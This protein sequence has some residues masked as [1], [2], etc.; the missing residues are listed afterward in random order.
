[1]TARSENEHS[2]AAQK[3]GA[4]PDHETACPGSTARAHGESGPEE[5]PSQERDC[6]SGPRPLMWTSSPFIPQSLRRG[7]EASGHVAVTQAAASTSADDADH[8]G[9]DAAAPPA[10]QDDSDQCQTEDR[11]RADGRTAVGGDAPCAMSPSP[12][13]PQ[14]P[15]S[16]A[17]RDLLVW[18]DCEFT[19]LDPECD[20]IIE[21]AV[22]ITD[23][24]LSPVVTFATPIR[25][26]EEVLQRMSLWA[27]QVHGGLYQRRSPGA[28]SASSSSAEPGTTAP[29][30][31]PPLRCVPCPRTRFRPCPPRPA[32][33]DGRPEPSLVDECRSDARSMPLADA[34]AHIVRILDAHR[35]GRRL[36]L[37]GSSVYIDKMFLRRWMPRVDERLHYRVIDVS[38]L[39]EVVR[40]FRPHLVRAQPANRVTHRALGDIFSSISLLRFYV[41]LLPPLLPAHAPVFDALDFVGPQHF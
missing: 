29:P 20:Q 41:A 38:S 30:P 17:R 31:L 19:G 3:S 36:T 32:A 14:A 24:R 21:I 10:V 23:W 40:R 6:T 15:S 13:L 8:R 34:E 2:Y 7:S 4:A 16:E 18:I 12:S 27:A 39:M 1:M 9:L 25:Q 5:V 35:H 26:P 33:A 11:K 37:A 22:V 28:A